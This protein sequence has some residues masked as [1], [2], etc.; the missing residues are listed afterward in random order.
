MRIEVL[1]GD[2]LG[3]QAR[4]YA[5]YRV[6]AALSHLADSERIRHVRVVLRR[7]NH[8]ARE[9]VSCAVTVY[10]EGAG[11]LRVRAS[12]DHP[13][14]A[15]NH[16]IELLRVGDPERRLAVGDISERNDVSL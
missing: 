14:A 5:E 10:R 12:G 3:Q 8:G 4:T 13:Y 15:I 2:W 16:A 11:H 1:G 9:G 7:S 6:F